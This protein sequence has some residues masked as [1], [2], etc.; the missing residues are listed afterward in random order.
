HLEDLLLGVEAQISVSVREAHHRLEW[1]SL[2]PRATFTVEHR[3]DD[4]THR[5]FGVH[6]VLHCLFLS[7]WLERRCRAPKVNAAVDS[8]AIYLSQLFFREFQHRKRT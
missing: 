1:H 8:V 6:S 4:S 3:H 2:R 7:R 5:T